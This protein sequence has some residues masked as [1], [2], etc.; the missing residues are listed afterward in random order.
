MASI[1]LYQAT[2]GRRLCRQLSE[3]FY[4]RAARDPVLRPFFPGKSLR[5]AVEAFAAFLAQFLG[6]PAE[7]AQKR[8]WLSL[9]E[10]HQRFKI[11]PRE[12]KA[13]MSNMLKALKDVPLEEP[14]RLAL[15]ALFERSSAYLVNTGQGVSETAAP[16]DPT[17][18]GIHREMTQRWGEQ[19]ALDDLIAA[20]QDGAAGRAIELT[21]SPMLELRFVRDR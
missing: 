13:W 10:S 21:Q 16:E 3:A 15:R 12:Q 19:R 14:V 17:D 8:W 2:G 4:S 6:G 18:D 5:C 20:I 11:G 7:D 9:R 1:D